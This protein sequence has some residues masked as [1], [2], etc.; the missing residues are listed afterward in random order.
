[1]GCFTEN[2]GKLVLYHPNVVSDNGLR[3]GNSNLS[4]KD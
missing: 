3:M 1:M 2:I 4:K